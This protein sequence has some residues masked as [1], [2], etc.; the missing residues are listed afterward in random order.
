MAPR[1]MPFTARS[2]R[3]A[4]IA[5]VAAAARAIS[6]Q[7]HCIAW[8]ASHQSKRCSIAHCALRLSGPPCP[9]P[10]HVSRDG[11]CAT[12]ARLCLAQC[13]CYR[14]EGIGA[15]PLPSFPP[16]ET[17]SGNPATGIAAAWG[18]FP[19]TRSALAG[20]TES[21]RKGIGSHAEDQSHRHRRRDG[22]RRDDPHHLEA[23]QG[24]ADPALRR[25]DARVLRPRHGVSRQDQRPGDDRRGQRHQEAR[26]RR[27]VRDHHAGRGAR[28]G[29][30]PQGDVEEPQRHDPQHPGRRHLPRA[31]HL[32]ERAA[33]GAGL[34]QAVRDRP[35]RLRRPVPRHRLPLP[36]QGHDHASSSRA[37]TAR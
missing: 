14:A 31:H 29:V 4:P 24:Q 8:S 35:P 1:S 3:S 30:Q 25:R 33:P 23:H 20:M 36:R 32:Q 16:S 2:M 18:G 10:E 5:D 19:L 21:A 15:L 7:R 9:N 17:Q 22:R 13:R 34:D 28:E 37:R 6:R 11:A 26:R 27:Q 12:R